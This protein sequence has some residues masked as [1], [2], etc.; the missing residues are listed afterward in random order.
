M[1][2]KDDSANEAA[3]DFALVCLY[4]LVVNVRESTRAV[5]L[6]LDNGHEA[7]YMLV[8]GPVVYTKRQQF[9]IRQALTFS[10]NNC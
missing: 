6:S 5:S 10:Q 9:Q 8:E 2:F 4:S 7:G 1:L 3:D